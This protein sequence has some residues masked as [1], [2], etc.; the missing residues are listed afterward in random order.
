MRRALVVVVAAI[1]LIAASTAVAHESP[2]RVLPDGST[3][4]G[5]DFSLFF[6]TDTLVVEGLD[7][8]WACP[9]AGKTH[10][11]PTFEILTHAGIGHIPASHQLVLDRKLAYTKVGG[12]NRLGTADVKLDVALAWGPETETTIRRATAKGSIVVKSAA[13]STGKLSV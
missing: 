3:S 7:V 8:Q 2:G 4:Q 12:T 6:D 10:V 13:C 11:A 1:A 5:G 9:V